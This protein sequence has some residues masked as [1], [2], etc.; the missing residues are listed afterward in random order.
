[1][2]VSGGRNSYSGLVRAKH[3][4]ETSDEEAEEAR[5]GMEEMSRIYEATGGEL[6]IGQ[7]NREHD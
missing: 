1:M 6:Y 3:K 5:E 2:R 4:R 7:R